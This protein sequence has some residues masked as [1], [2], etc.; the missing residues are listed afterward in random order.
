MSDCECKVEAKNAGQRKTLGILLLVNLTMF[1][2]ESLGGVIAQST[3]LVADSLDML[4]DATVYAISLY[5]V[6]HSDSQKSR[7]AF[8]SGIFQI[9]LAVLV[10]FEVVK[11]IIWGSFP[12]FLWMSG[13][14]ILAL[15]ANIYCLLLISKY[16]D[17][18]VHMR[19]SW[20]FSK[21]D[22][23]ANISVIIAGVMVNIFNSPIPDLVVG[24][25]IAVLVLSGGF[26]IIRE[27]QSGNK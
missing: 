19:A 25:G 23:I 9:T 26:T 5:A 15:I 13:I 22:V 21:N 7:A 3:A 27:S 24:I 11:K 20:I 17:D 6:S 8:L 1:F 10:L 16:R 18:E 2:L 4:A 12:E 14:G